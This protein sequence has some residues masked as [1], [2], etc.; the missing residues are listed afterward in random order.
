MFAQASLQE[1]EINLDTLPEFH[2]PRRCVL[3]EKL[4]ATS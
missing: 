2:L 3:D 1:L 4:V